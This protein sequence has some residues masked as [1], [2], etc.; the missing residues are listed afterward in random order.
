MPPPFVQNSLPM[1]VYPLLFLTLCVR[2]Q[3][4]PPA[5]AD[6]S[7]PSAAL[8]SWMTCLLPIIGNLTV[9][10]LQLPGTHDTLSFDLSNRIADNANDID[11][12]LASFLHDLIRP[13]V[14]FVGDF[15]KTM[16][17]TQRQSIPQQL[18]AGMR[19][20]D[21]R[22]TFSR[23]PAAGAYEWVG[24]HFVE[25]VLAFTEYLADIRRWLDAH[26]Q[27]LI[28][29]SVTRHGSFCLNGPGQFPGCDQGQ[30][31]ALWQAVTAT[32]HGLLVDHS[33]SSL[34][35]TTLLQ[36]LD[37]GQRVVV[38]AAPPLLKHACVL[39][40]T[41]FVTLCVRY[42]GDYAALTRSSALAL[43]ACLITNVC[44][45]DISDVQQSAV[46]IMAFMKDLRALRAASKRN[47]TFVLLSLADAA[48][49]DMCCSFSCAHSTALTFVPP[50]S[51]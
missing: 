28:V 15:I 14:A 6:C 24:L 33:L 12:A 35:D 17:V 42:A 25:T 47:N 20:L 44:L 10:D 11:P 29:L 41:C 49:N 30:K 27:E 34:N 5:T 46:A 16:A 36:L 1:H 45:Q 39:L 9:L 18:D 13:P 8:S 40:H 51:S 26:P 31:D 48:S 3:L 21:L 37:H 32:F 23:P 19:F 50:G 4:A 38:C 43:D 7:S 2:A 22:C